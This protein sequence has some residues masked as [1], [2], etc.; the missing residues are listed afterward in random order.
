MGDEDAWEP[1]LQTVTYESLM[2]YGARVAQEDREAELLLKDFLENPIAV[3]WTSLATRRAFRTGGVVRKLNAA[4]H[5]ICEDNPLAALTFADA[6]V[7]VAGALPDDLYPANAVYQLRGTAWK[8][9]AIAQ[10]LLGLLPEA[11]TS[12]DSARRAYSKTAHNGLG[13]ALVALIRAGV[14]YEQGCFDDAL[15]MAREAEIGLAHAGDDRRRMDA[16]FLQGSIMYEVGSIQGAITLFRQIIDYGEHLQSPRWIARGFYALGNCEIEAGNLSDASLHF[17]EA[18][19]IFRGVGPERHRI[20]TE[21]GIARVVLHS[22]KFTEA[23]RRLRIAAGDFERLGMVT[24]AALVGLDITEALLALGKP[25]QIVEL[26]QHLFGVF[27]AAGTL[28]E[29]LAAIAYLKEAAAS[30]EL[31]TATLKNLR[32]FLRRAER[33]PGLQFVPPPP[34]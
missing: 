5:A 3:A 31:T 12:L 2:A 19:V 11:H 24:D 34:A 30:G 1:S 33:Q 28:T 15:D 29:A 8:E 6:A 7:S 21:W 20:A 17:H 25:R 22:G 23:V 27:Q 13:L 9:R 4:A 26:A 14:F 18:L 16:V 10:M 32:S